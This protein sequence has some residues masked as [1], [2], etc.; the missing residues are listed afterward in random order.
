MLFAT[1]SS[2]KGFLC[3]RS[4]SAATAVGGTITLVASIMQILVS[5]AVFVGFA[6]IFESMG[7]PSFTIR[8]D[9]STNYSDQQWYAVILYIVLA[10]LDFV[11]VFLSIILL[12]GI[13]RKKPSCWYFY[14]WIIFMPFYLVYESAINIFFFVTSFGARNGTLAIG[15]V[16]FTEQATR[17]GFLVTPLIYWIVKTLIVLA[18]WFVVIFFC[19]ELKKGKYCSCSQCQYSSEVTVLPR[20]PPPPVVGPCIYNRPPL[21]PI[22]QK[23][24]TYQL[25]GCNPGP[26]CAQRGFYA[27]T[28]QYKVY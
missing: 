28:T 1:M 20:P 5:V 26:Y 23:P 7:L 2:C 13:D 24:P 18:F 27:P 8:L 6:E 11:I 17:F 4:L 10:C 25:A 16:L 15:Q 22:Y 3:F 19:I 21:I 12:F 9:P 14:P